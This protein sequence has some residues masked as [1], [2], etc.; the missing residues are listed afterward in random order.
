MNHRSTGKNVGNGQR[1]GSEKQSWHI[2]RELLLP[3]IWCN[4]SCYNRTSLFHD[5]DT[6]TQKTP[7]RLLRSVNKN[8]EKQYFF[9]KVLTSDALILMLRIC[10]LW[11]WLYESATLAWPL[12]DLSSCVQAGRH[13]NLTVSKIL[14]KHGRNMITTMRVW[15][16]RPP[17]TCCP[18]CYCCCCVHTALTAV[19]VL[20]AWTH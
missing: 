4:S 1:R 2:K 13:L 20:R 19:A 9:Y 12:S 7:A 6:Q 10:L 3:F 5:I 17:D 8:T 15:S 11:V 14:P 18:C 16:G